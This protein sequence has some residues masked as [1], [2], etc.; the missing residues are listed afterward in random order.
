MSSWGT[1]TGI[2]MKL[3]RRYSF[4]G[5]RHSFLSAGCPAPEGMPGAVFVLA[6]TTFSFAGG[7]SL[8]TSLS[9]TCEVRR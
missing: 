5:L 3:A 6:R 8:G 4:H 2:E 9:R 7:K 1:V